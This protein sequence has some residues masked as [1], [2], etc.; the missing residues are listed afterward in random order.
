MSETRGVDRGAKQ[1]DDA[2]GSAESFQSLEN[3]LRKVQ[4]GGEAVDVEDWIFDEDWVAPGAS[5]S[6]IMAFDMAVDCSA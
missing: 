5:F 2:R 4:R 6:G 3:L 1:L